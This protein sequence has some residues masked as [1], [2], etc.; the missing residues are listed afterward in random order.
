VAPLPHLRFTFLFF[1]FST[2]GGTGRFFS[3]TKS[4]PQKKQILFFMLGSPPFFSRFVLPFHAFLESVLERKFFFSEDSFFDPLSVGWQK[5]F[6]WPSLPPRCCPQKISVFFL[7][8]TFRLV[9]LLYKVV[10]RG[11]TSVLKSLVRSTSVAFFSGSW[12]PFFLVDF[13]PH[14]PHSYFCTIVSLYVAFPHLG[15]SC[16]LKTPPQKLRVIPIVLFDPF[17]FFLNFPRKSPRSA[18]THSFPLLKSQWTFF[19]FHSLLTQ[20]FP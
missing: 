10:P 7:N 4:C 2:W 15:F 1:I 17:V 18:I 6:P 20:S 9:P 5:N 12:R 13:F 19:F 8:Q 16:S 14:P 3:G 11:G